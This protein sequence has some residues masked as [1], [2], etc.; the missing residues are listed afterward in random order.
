MAMDQNRLIG[1]DGGMPWHVPGEQA[2]FKRVTMGKPIIMGRKTYDSLG[3]PL[4]GRANIVVTRNNQWHAD[5]VLKRYR[6]R[7][8]CSRWI[9]FK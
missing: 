8:Y 6:E 7:N 3:R 5:G 9:C 1:K 2:Y 4:P